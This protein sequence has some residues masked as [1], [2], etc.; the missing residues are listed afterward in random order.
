MK[1]EKNQSQKLQIEWS[2]EALEGEI[3]IYLKIA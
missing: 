3:T 2:K 1:K